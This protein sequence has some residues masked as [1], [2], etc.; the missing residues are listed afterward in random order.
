MDGYM[1][2][3]KI[4]NTATAG[5]LPIFMVHDDGDVSCFFVRAADQQTAE[6]MFNENV[7]IRMALVAASMHK[8]ARQRAF[9]A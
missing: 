5:D 2:Y 9:V 3:E 1:T 6:V 7:R 8:E 4:V